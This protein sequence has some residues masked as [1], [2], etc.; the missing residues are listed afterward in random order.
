MK[1][2]KNKIF[3][4]IRLQYFVRMETDIFKK[5]VEEPKNVLNL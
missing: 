5:K 1:Q 4:C 3:N 2:K